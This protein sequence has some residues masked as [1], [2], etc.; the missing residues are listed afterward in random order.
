MKKIKQEKGVT[1]SILVITVITLL[2]I[3]ST[4][5]YNAQ[6]TAQL[7]RLTNLYNDIELLRE[8]VSEYYN[9]YG[10]IPAETKYVNIGGLKSVLSTK[11]DT[12]DFYVIDLEAMQGITLNYGKDYQKIKND[13]ESASSYTDIYI[14]NENSHNIF[15]VSGITIKDNK[16]T[17]TYYTDY[18]MPDDTVVDLRYIEGILIPENYYYIGKTKDNNGNES[19]VISNYRNDTVNTENT[20]QYTWTKQIS[21]LE[22]VPSS[23]KLDSDQSEEEFLES[24]NANKGYFRNSEGRVR[25]TK[26][27]I[28]SAADMFDE[29][30]KI[31]GR[32]HVGDYVEY[33][34]D[35]ASTDSI[36]TE[37][38]TYSGSSSNTTSTLKQENLNWR[39][40]DVKDGQ[41]RLISEKPTTSKIILEG[42]KG[43]NNA[44]Y[45]L[46]KT[47]N[48]LYNSTQIA[49]KVQ[50]I[51]IEDIQE[52]L[53]YDYT[54]HI[55][56]NIDTGKYG[57][58]KTYTTNKYYPNLFAKEK[59]GWVDG[60]Q[61]T[62]L[63]L[64]IQAKPIDET[65]TQAGT[66]IKI[67]QT[68]WNKE[69]TTD[70][71]T[72]L[73]YYE[74]FVNDG[75][76]NYVTYWMSSRSIGANPDSA[77]FRVR[78]VGGGYVDS[79]ALYVSDGTINKKE[80]AFRPIITLKSDVQ[81]DKSNS[82]DGS[83]ATQA[84]T[85]K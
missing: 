3:T 83:T 9:E 47:C 2:I 57:G 22:E 29:T 42:P 68:N 10:Q 14:I 39:V 56:A 62:E 32:L 63:E 77:N 75:T 21:S 27:I 71:F 1:L 15:Y 61:G 35:T 78:F 84:Y 20:N 76:S 53:V 52:Q 38:G 50:N 24:V 34:P 74:L 30:G 13:K 31:R 19:I 85:I 64:S 51:K 23:I 66:S 8:K 73:K 81:I 33:T 36:L 55:N 5:I 80:Y 54:Q 59:T 12:G 69:M 46:D 17:K 18:L 6:D 58:T 7:K 72:K 70:D 40:L 26:A 41:L 67:T 82:G 16:M 79:S 37:L 44:V 48:T 25:Y 49:S 28:T 60:I 65:N 43:Y 4:L 45:L 11:N